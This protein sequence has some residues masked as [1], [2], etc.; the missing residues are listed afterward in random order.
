MTRNVREAMSWCFK[1]DIKVIVKPLTNK[2]KPEVKLQ[3][4]R[5]G[6]IQIGKEIYKQDEKLSIKIQELYL[7]LYNTLR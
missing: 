3:I 4:H 1:N 7:Y 6:N 5:L 2:R